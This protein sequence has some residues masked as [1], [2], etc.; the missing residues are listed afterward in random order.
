[1]NSIFIFIFYVSICIYILNRVDV[2]EKE[3]HSG[4][5]HQ[6]FPRV[7]IKIKGPK[8]I[9]TVA[10]QISGVFH[11]AIF[12]MTEKISLYCSRRK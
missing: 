12:M 2:R 8:S 4:I 9:I 7:L 3:F 10:L 6:K 5:C 11:N 1:M